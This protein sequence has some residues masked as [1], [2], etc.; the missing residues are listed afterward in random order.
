MNK[1]P[2]EKGFCSFSV[3]KS[4]CFMSKLLLGQFHLGVPHPLSAFLRLHLH[5]LIPRKSVPLP[6]NTGVLLSPKWRPTGYITVIYYGLVLGAALGAAINNLSATM[7]S[8]IA[9]ISPRMHEC[10][11]SAAINCH[12]E[13][14]TPKETGKGKRTMG[15][16]VCL[17]TNNTV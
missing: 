4:V 6:T 5:L 10:M 9:F 2:V 14:R 12:P 11:K 7:E 1:F 17:L 8:T 16:M 15:N 13:K 3:Y